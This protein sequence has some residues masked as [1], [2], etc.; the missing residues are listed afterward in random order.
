[1]I[2]T[3]FRAALPTAHR[4]AVN[5]AATRRRKLLVLFKV[6]EATSAKAVGPA[7]RS[8]RSGELSCYS[9]LPTAHREAVNLAATRRRKLLVLFKVSEA[10]SAKAVGPADRRRRRLSALP[11]NVGV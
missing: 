4:E 9:A 10:T 2:H 3:E 11:T 8:P 7:D 1:M 6:S 5:L